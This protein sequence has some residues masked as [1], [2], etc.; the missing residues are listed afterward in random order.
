MGRKNLFSAFEGFGFQ[1]SPDGALSCRLKTGDF[2]WEPPAHVAFLFY[3]TY[4]RMRLRL[5]FVSGFD[6]LD[7][8]VRPAV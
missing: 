4:T 7:H 3:F 5:R 8:I 6:E 1:S 2:Q